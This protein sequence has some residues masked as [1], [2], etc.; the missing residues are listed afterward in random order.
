MIYK[1]AIEFFCNI[2]IEF[3]FLEWLAGIM[4][5]FVIIYLFRAKIKLGSLTIEN[6]KIKIPIVNNSSC[7]MATN[8]IIEAAI[9]SN[10]QTF[11]FKLDRDK[12]ILVPRKCKKCNNEQNIRSFYALDFEEV[13]ISLMGGVNSYLQIINNIPENI[14][15]RVRVH[16]N[17]E[18]TNFGKAFEFNYKYN[19]GHFIKINN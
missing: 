19:N 18:F 8:I 3:N 16:A 14:T 10:N 7:F 9:I 12:F 5:T 13:T 2:P 17:H 4:T 11:H 6:N 1:G 15:L